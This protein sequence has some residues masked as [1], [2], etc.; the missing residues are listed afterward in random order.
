L[1]DALLAESNGSDPLAAAEEIE[2][3]IAAADTRIQITNTTEAELVQRLAG[4]MRHVIQCEADE[5]DAIARARQAELDQHLAKLQ[6]LLDE[7]AHIDGCQFVSRSVS[8]Q[9]QHD[10]MTRIPGTT[11]AQP[12][13]IPMTH[14]M[15][16]ATA[17]HNARSEARRLRSREV[18]AHGKAMG[19]TPEQILEQ[20]H[21]PLV[22]SPSEASIRYAMEQA[23]TAAQAKYKASGDDQIA[24]RE[25]GFSGTRATFT[26]TWKSGVVQNCT[27]KI[28]ATYTP[29]TISS[30]QQLVGGARYGS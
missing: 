6:P 2:R 3:Q 14:T 11:L 22:I 26:L 8:L 1:T 18:R 28:E 29:I 13:A 27:A 23:E 16:Y 25:R 30:Q 20:C 21:A 10:L 12:V 15:R 24:Q 4:A 19:Y 9:I 5:A 17:V 7:A